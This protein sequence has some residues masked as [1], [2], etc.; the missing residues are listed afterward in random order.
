[1][2]LKHVTHL[3]ALK[4]SNQQIHDNRHASFVIAIELLLRNRYSRAQTVF[5]CFYFHFR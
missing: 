4:Y 3:K 2:Y 1:M 5:V